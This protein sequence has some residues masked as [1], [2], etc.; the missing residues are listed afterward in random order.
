MKLYAGAEKVDVTP[1]GP[2]WMDGMIRAS[3]SEGV[4]DRLHARA[5]VVSPDARAVERA[6]ALVAVDVCALEAADAEAMR[7]EAASRTGLA[8][9]RIVI[10]ASHTHSG[11]AAVGFFNPKESSYVEL[12]ARRVVEA[13]V[14]AAGRLAP[15]RIACGRGR[16]EGISYYRRLLADDGHVVMN[17]ETFPPERIVRVLGEADPE[18]GVVRV[19]A[20]DPRAGPIALVFHHAGHP[21]ALSG[22]NLLLSG[23]Y[24]SAAAE[25][26][27]RRFGGVALYLNGAQGSV[28]I[29]NFADRGWEGRE[30]LGARL[31]DA[32][33]GVIGAGLGMRWAPLASARTS[34]TI[35]A[36]RIG[37]EELAWAAA[38]LRRTGGAVQPL[39]D[40]VGDDYRA[41][42]YLELHERQ[43]TPIAVEQVCVAFGDCALVSFPGELYTEIGAELKRRSPFALT[44]PV[45]LANG[46]I[47]YVPTPQAIREGG[48]AEDTRRV[49]A[50]AADI[51]LERSLELLRE[52]RAK[53]ARSG[54]REAEDA[55]KP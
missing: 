50:A 4:H 35:P 46:C 9:E 36:R 41:R 18:V 8:P 13:V 5:L 14:A 54:G 53:L 16:A 3:R 32:V 39:E 34:Y 20:D 28:D 42:L 29:D 23:D 45:G 33:S 11:P 10:A 40:G 15:A 26:L 37:D 27:E 7:R 17:W 31:A 12:L 6:V 55:W 30:R 24:V 2:V 1:E 21:N 19:S 38:V 43:D 51:V 25:S 49:D 22:A 52:T 47:G 44:L 48:Y